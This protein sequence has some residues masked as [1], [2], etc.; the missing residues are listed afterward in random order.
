[1]TDSK[2]FHLAA[3]APAILALLLS[4]PAAA[5]VSVTKSELE[6]FLPPPGLYRID[7]DSP[8]RPNV[9]APNASVDQRESGAQSTRCVTPGTFDYSALPTFPPSA[10]CTTQSLDLVEGRLTHVAICAMGRITTTM[11]KTAASTWEN[12][13]NAAMTQVTSLPKLDAFRPMLENEA[14]NGATQEKRDKAAKMLADLPAKQ[15][16]MEARRTAKLEEM[17]AAEAKSTSPQE[18][19]SLQKMI[20]ALR[21]GP[22][23]PV[24]N[25]STRKETWTLIGTSCQ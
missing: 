7:S 19:E 2:R 9:P 6:A 23:D 12:E 13:I 17:T 8:I 15:A 16:A 24:V 1:M 14:L 22:N 3:A 21:S 20:A 11:R 10:R 4:Q 18:K 5:G 25:N